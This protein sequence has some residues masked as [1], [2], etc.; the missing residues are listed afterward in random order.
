MVI[1]VEVPAPVL[2]FPIFR[3]SSRIERYLLYD[4]SVITWLRKNHHIPGVLIGTLPQ[5]PQQN[6]FLGLPLELMPEEAR[7][8]CEKRLAYT[9]DD[10]EWHQEGIRS[11]TADQRN[12]FTRDIAREGGEAA[13]VAGRK[14]LESTERALRKLRLRNTPDSDSASGPIDDDDSVQDVQDTET[15]FS[16]TPRRAGPTPVPDSLQYISTKEAWGI[17]PTTAYP[18][19]F[20]PPEDSGKSLPN[21]RASSYELFKHLHAHNYYMSPGLR[22]GCQFLVYPGDPLRFHS[23]FLCMGMD[24]DEEI[25]LLDLVG[26]G[27]LGTGVK[28]GWL[29]GGVE[30]RFGDENSLVTSRVAE[31]IAENLITHQNTES[32]ERSI[33][34]AAKASKSR[35]RTFCIE[36]GGM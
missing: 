26:G 35:V 20:I 9:A 32:K 28:K 23:H 3:I 14:K 7:F 10:L 16:L 13:K 36:W 24:W 6:V 29:I 21:V 22:F 31:K 4:I 25:S 15:L 8:L 18:P 1:P 27:R 34:M 12:A 11:L 30:D 2:P 5:I 19:L 33:R 17:T